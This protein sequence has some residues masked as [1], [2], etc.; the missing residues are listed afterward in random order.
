[1]R[2][3]EFMDDGAPPNLAWTSG[4]GRDSL[5]LSFKERRLEIAD[6]SRVREPRFQAVYI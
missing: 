3:G 1:V 4:K 6:P 2:Y 5:G